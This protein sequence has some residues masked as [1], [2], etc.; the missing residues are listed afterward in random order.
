LNS[1]QTK[2]LGTP[3]DFNTTGQLLTTY[4]AFVI[5]LRKDGNRI[6]QSL[7]YYVDFKQAYDS[8]RNEVL[9]S[10]LIEF[11]IPMKLVRQIKLCLK[12]IAES[13]QANIHLAFFLL[14]IL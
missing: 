2:F 7:S 8:V 5:L 11:A 13:R 12:P 6:K 3:L 14:R 4:S 10:I 9:Y 1:P